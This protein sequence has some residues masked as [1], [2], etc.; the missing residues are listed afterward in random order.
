MKRAL[1]IVIATV[2]LC[3]AGGCLLTE[4]FFCK[5]VKDLLTH[6]EWNVHNVSLLRLGRHFRITPSF[7]LIVGRD[8]KENERIVSCASPE[9]VVVQSKEI[10]GPVALG[11]GVMEERFKIISARIVARYCSSVNGV[12]KIPVSITV[13]GIEEVVVVDK[14]KHDEVERL[15]I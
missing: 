2:F 12:V 6:G 15:R 1:L 7:K 11:I 13:D 10:K 5:K 14:F 3:A 9:Q 8:Q 4:P